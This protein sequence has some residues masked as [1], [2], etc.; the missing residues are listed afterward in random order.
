MAERDGEGGAEGLAFCQFL[1]KNSIFKP[2]RHGTVGVV[3]A[4]S[5][6]QYVFDID[7]QKGSLKPLNEAQI[8]NLDRSAENP[9]LAEQLRATIASRFPE[10]VREGT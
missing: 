6:H 3:D 1:E 5:Q 8:W 10:I 9:A 4:K 7:T 2:L